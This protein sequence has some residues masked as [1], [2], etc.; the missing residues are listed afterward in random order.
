MSA[1][2]P[3]PWHFVPMAQMADCNEQGPMAGVFDDDDGEMD[4]LIATAEK[5]ADARLMA[6]APDLLDALLDVR[7]QFFDEPEVGWRGRMLARVDDAIAK[8]T[9]GSS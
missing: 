6:A 4:A 3:G 2:T 9:G 5:D 1:H 7:N 8:A